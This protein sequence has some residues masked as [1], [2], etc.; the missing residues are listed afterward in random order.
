MCFQLEAKT[1]LF[2]H[3]LFILI[4]FNCFRKKFFS[5]SHKLIT[6]NIGCQSILKKY[7]K[8]EHLLYLSKNKLNI[9]SEV[10]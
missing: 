3:N 2:S 1:I 9:V 6:F 8:F 7:L 10:V 4:Q 5:I